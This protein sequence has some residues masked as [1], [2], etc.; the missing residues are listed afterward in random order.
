MVGAPPLL[1]LALCTLLGIILTVVGSALG[2]L[3]GELLLG[4]SL[5]VLGAALLSLEELGEPLGAAAPR[6]ALSALLG[7]V[8]LTVGC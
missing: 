4:N 7:G 6:V 1:G 2:E 8:I 3:L 5:K